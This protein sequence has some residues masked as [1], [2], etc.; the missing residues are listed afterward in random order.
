VHR[1]GVCTASS[2]KISALP[3]PRRA[4]SAPTLSGGRGGQV[5][6]VAEAKRQEERKALGLG[7]PEAETQGVC[8]RPPPS[9]SPHDSIQIYSEFRTISSSFY[10]LLP[11]RSGRTTATVSA[12]GATGPRQSPAPPRA[13]PRRAAAVKCGAAAALGGAAGG[14]GVVGGGGGEKDAKLAQKLGQLQPFGAVFPQEC[15]GQFASANLTTFTLGGQTRIE[16]LIDG[17]EAQGLDGICKVPPPARPPPRPPS[18]PPRRQEARPSNARA[19]PTKF[20]RTKGVA[21]C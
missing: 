3:A 21:A 18:P 11:H 17:V 12:T 9:L 6:R 19:V 14:G 13:A 1:E 5:E 15:M 16:E 8:R 4:R 7:E 20:R 10:N 2:W